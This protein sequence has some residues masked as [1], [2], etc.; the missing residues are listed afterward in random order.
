MALIKCPECGTEFSE[1]AKEC[2]KCACPIDV[3]KTQINTENNKELLDKHT[4]NVISNEVT[5]VEVKSTSKEVSSEPNQQDATNMVSNTEKGGIY[6]LRIILILLFVVFIFIVLCFNTCN[7][8]ISTD[9]DSTLTY[10]DTC[11][12]VNDK[13][14]R[15]SVSLDSCLAYTK[16]MLSEEECKLFLKR[17][18]AITEVVIIYNDSIE[19]RHIPFFVQYK[20]SLAHNDT[21]MYFTSLEDASKAYIDNIKKDQSAFSIN[22]KCVMSQYDAEVSSLKAV[23][24][25]RKLLHEKEVEKELAQS[26]KEEKES[27]LKRLKDACWQEDIDVQWHG[28]TITFIGWEFAANKNK[29]FFQE[30]M[31]DD[32]KKYGFKRVI[33]KWTKSASEYTYYDI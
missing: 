4:N 7:S 10:E 11:C 23:V 13:K 21:T 17:V 27:Y 16:N 15:V 8:N 9:E 5:S 12:I 24:E 18:Q 28:T 20:Y 25:S 22:E 19:G 14:L 3:V 33:Y 26:L 31:R 1:F 6:P 2:P 30:K 32:L 29:Q